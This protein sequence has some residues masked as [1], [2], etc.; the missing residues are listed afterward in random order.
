MSK[1]KKNKQTKKKQNVW[2][3]TFAL[4]SKNAVSAF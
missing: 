4:Q 3:D 1:K 2:H